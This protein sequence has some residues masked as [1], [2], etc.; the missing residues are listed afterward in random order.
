[1]PIYEY[2]CNGCGAESE[3]RQE[4]DSALP[5]CC[6]KEME[7]LV[8]CPMDLPTGTERSARRRWA[9]DWTPDSVGISTGSLH[10]AR[11]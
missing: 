4:L 8:S 1:M 11:Y 9:R 3:K 2:R 6:G 5:L 7:K 10:G